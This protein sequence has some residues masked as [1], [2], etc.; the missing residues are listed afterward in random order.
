MEKSGDEGLVEAYL[1]L[2]NA[3]ACVGK[4]EAW[5][6]REPIAQKNGLINGTAKEKKEGKRG[7]VT[8]DDIR[9]EYQEELDRLAA[10]EHGRFAFH[11]EDGDEMDVL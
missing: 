2:I 9:R 3:M 11:D 1:L 7:L 6:I 4:E 5:V 10:L 8:L